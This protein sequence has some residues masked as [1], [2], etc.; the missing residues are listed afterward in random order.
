[1]KLSKKSI[2][3]SL[4]LCIFMFMSVI[5]STYVN[6]QK[7]IK[8]RDIKV[9]INT[10]NYDQ[11]VDTLKEKFSSIQTS[12]D[13]YNYSFEG[14]VE[15]PGLDLLSTTSNINGSAKSK[16]SSKINKTDDSFV[17][18]KSTVVNQEEVASVNKSFK[19]KYDE[20]NDKYYIIDE[21]GNELDLL[22]ELAAD[23]IEDCFVLTAIFTYISAKEIIVLCAV[24]ATV[25]FVANID[26]IANDVQTLISGVKDGAMSFWDRLKLRLGKITAISL[27]NAI[28]LTAALA[29]EV[30]EVAKKRK[31]CYLLCGTVTGSGFIPVLYK[32]TNYEN[33]RNWIKKGGTVW[34]P[35]AGTAQRCIEGAGYTPGGKDKDSNQYVPYVAEIHKVAPFAYYHYHTLMKHSNIRVNNSAHS[36]FGL[37]YAR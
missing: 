14:E 9:D 33:A 22:S 30:Y 1:M 18:K 6:V 4:V 23:N 35:Y 16:Y 10:T 17:I 12:D 24:I 32:F 11:I 34:S 36:F 7:D 28:S 21:N 26:V 27:K 8:I 20:S 19:T 5:F 29:V 3:I 25:I 13:E 2:Y 37:P 31:D 15:L